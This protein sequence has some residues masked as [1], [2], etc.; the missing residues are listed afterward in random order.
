MI[1]H[2]QGAC[3]AG[4]CGCPPC[5]GMAAGDVASDHNL[6]YSD[7]ACD[8]I[9]PQ[10]GSRRGFYAGVVQLHSRLEQNS[11]LVIR[12]IRPGS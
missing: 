5:F 6:D 1:G 9:H 10:P 12:R 8:L 4:M 11:A 3:V 2:P 7:P